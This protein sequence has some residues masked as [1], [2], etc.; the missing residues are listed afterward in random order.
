[1]Q[2][3]LS[4]AI[5][6]ISIFLIGIVLVQPS[7]TDGFQGEAPAL[8][9]NRYGKNKTEELLKNSTIV[10][11]VLFIVLTLLLAIIS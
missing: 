5:G 3:F 8:G 6:I 10:L 2:I 9:D 7:K 11:S 1:M 4:V